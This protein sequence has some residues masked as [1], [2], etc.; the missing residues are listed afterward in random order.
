M[1][2]YSGANCHKPWTIEQL[3][4]GEISLD[5]ARAGGH[6]NEIITFELRGKLAHVVYVLAGT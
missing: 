5:K 1:L 2:S 4:N 6:A 3:I